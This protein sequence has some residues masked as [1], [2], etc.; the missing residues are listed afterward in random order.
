MHAPDAPGRVPRGLYVLTPESLSGR[1]LVQAVADALAGGA[2]LVQYRAKAGA[3][4]ADALAL[5]SVCRDQG[6][7]L[8]V[9]DDPAL[10]ARIGADGVHVGRDDTACT[11]AR[12][13]L[14]PAA[15]IGVSCYDRLDLALAAA[16]AGADYVAFGSFFPSGT[17]PHAVRPPPGLLEQAR[18]RIRLPIVAIGGITPDNGASLLAAGA[19]LLAVIAGV[20]DAADRRAAASRYARLFDAHSQPQ[21]GPA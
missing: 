6:I 20:F 17:K 14:G 13:L 12:E 3:R 2:R 5:Q 7:P 11:A 8:I 21:D 4:L 10:A 16:K 19:D 9:N 18:R 1:P 15:I